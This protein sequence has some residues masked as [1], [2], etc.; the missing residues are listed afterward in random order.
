MS[1]FCLSIAALMPYGK[2]SRPT[3]KFAAVC[4]LESAISGYLSRNQPRG[5]R[6]LLSSRV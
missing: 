3:G 2:D 1:E 4:Q 5:N 6:D